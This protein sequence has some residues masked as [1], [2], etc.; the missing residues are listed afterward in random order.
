MENA[1]ARTLCVH[2]CDKD[3]LRSLFRALTLPEF[4]NVSCKMCDMLFIKR[5]I[6]HLGGEEETACCT[7]RQLPEHVLTMQTQGWTM[8]ISEGTDSPRCQ[9]VEHSLT[10]SR[11]PRISPHLLPH[12]GLDFG[13]RRGPPLVPPL[14]LK[15]KMKEMKAQK[16]TWHFHNGASC[17]ESFLGDSQ[18]HFMM[19]NKL[20]NIS[21]LNFKTAPKCIPSLGQSVKGP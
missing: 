1:S 18:R 5:F 13:L 14:G 16:M 3:T 17:F 19:C 6:P 12:C 2:T 11:G 15:R 4:S 8:Q 21:L 9:L 20:L 7:K 10:P